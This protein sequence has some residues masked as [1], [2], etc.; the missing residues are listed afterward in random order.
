MPKMKKFSNHLEKVS[1]FSENFNSTAPIMIAANAV[2]IGGYAVAAWYAPSETLRKSMVAAAAIATSNFPWTFIAI[3][4]T[5]L[6]LKK[7]ESAKDSGKAAAE[8]D[9]LLDRWN[10]RNMIRLSILAVA[11]VIGARELSNSTPL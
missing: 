8:A 5:V 9:K 3:I 1:N 10:S 4:P 6:E 2:A 7:I 11:M